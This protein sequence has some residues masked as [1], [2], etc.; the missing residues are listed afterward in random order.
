MA[1]YISQRLFFNEQSGEFVHRYQVIDIDKHQA[2]LILE[3]LGNDALI[4]ADS[5]VESNDNH[6]EEPEEMA[7]SE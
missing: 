7:S 2:K 5:P 1:K 6:T 4:S 3:T